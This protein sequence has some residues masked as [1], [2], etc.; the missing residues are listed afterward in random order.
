MSSLL[1][2][3]VGIL[4]LFWKLL[5][6]IADADTSR[7]DEATT[8]EYSMRSTVEIEV[9][10]PEN[11]T[12]AAIGAPPLTLLAYQTWKHEVV[13]AGQAGENAGV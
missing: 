10:V 5:F 6:P 9:V 7:G 3:V 8:P 13:P 12:V 1:A 11:V 4:P 2:V